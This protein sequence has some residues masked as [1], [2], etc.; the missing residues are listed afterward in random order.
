MQQKSPFADINNSDFKEQL[1]QQNFALKILFPC[2]ES[3]CDHSKQYSISGDS[4]LSPWCWYHK[5]QS[6]II[7]AIH[8]AK[9]ARTHPV[10]RCVFATQAA[11]HSY[12]HYS[13]ISSRA[14]A[15]WQ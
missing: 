12:E 14:V 4:C 5:H 2:S 3:A 6:V 10:L 7:D 8:L 1:E 11:D 9:H 13:T 15:K